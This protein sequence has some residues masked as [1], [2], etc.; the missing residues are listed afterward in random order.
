M[1]KIDIESLRRDF[2]KERDELGKIIFPIVEKYN[3]PQKELIEVCQ[4]GKFIY[5][6]NENLSIVDKPNPPRPDFILQN[7]LQLIGLEHTRIFTENSEKYNR[8]KSLFEYSEK[9]FTQLFPNEKIHAS[10]TIY[11]D[12]F[13][14]KQFQKKELA[15]KI[16]NYIQSLILNEKVEKPDFIEEIRLMKHSSVSFTFNEK[17]WQGPYLTNERLNE[18]IKKKEPK[19]QIYKNGENEIGEYWLILLIGSLSS[20]SYQLDE[21]ENY[22]TESDFNRVY[23]MADFDAKIVR[24]K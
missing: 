6:L 10:I 2:D 8:I 5:K 20:V 4:V 15:N 14:Y 9:I 24:V 11:N 1:N 18:E 13:E 22:Q 12:S 16:S 19:L 7:N 21:M 17:N 23:L 3:L